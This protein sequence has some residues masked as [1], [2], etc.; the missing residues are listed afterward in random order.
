[1]NFQQQ[2][3]K[4]LQ[5]NP[6]AQSSEPLVECQPKR[7]KEENNIKTICSVVSENRSIHIKGKCQE[8]L[9]GVGF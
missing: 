6:G 4:H 9:G 8:G 3:E 7:T 5:E 2:H 1:M